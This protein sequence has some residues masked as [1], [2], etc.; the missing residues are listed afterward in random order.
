MRRILQVST[1]V[2]I[3][4]AGWFVWRNTIK[5]RASEL[6][7][8]RLEDTYKVAGQAK[9]CLIFAYTRL[10]KLPNRR[11]WLGELHGANPGEGCS[12]S[13]RLADLEAKGQLVYLGAE[14][15]SWRGPKGEYPALVI[16]VGDRVT[17]K[18][19]CFGVDQELEGVA[20]YTKIL[21]CQQGR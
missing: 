8:E 13:G 5:L 6:Y 12:V 10:G 21:E 9:E 18:R 1:A 3:A 19:T 16:T 14:T 11:G 2:I 4:V 20:T 15:S 17:S 7:S